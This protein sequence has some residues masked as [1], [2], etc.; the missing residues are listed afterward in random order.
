[1]KRRF[2][3]TT[4]SKHHEPIAPNLLNRQFSANRPNQC[5]VGDITYIPTQE[6]WL[7]LSVVIA[8][9]SR[10]VVGWSMGKHMNA[11]L[12]NESLLM[13]IW[14]RKPPKGLVWHSDCSS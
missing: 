9:Y 1:M 12:V 11:S 8:L 6:G 14:K 2:K 7:Y 3:I 10:H 13:A 5:Y 4:Y